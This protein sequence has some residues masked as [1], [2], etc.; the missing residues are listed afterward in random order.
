M[1]LRYILFVVLVFYLWLPGP[2]T[3]NFQLE[4]GGAGDYISYGHLTDAFLAGKVHLLKEPDPKLI[5][6][7]NPYDRWARGD[8]GWHDATYYKE[9]YYLY[10]GA[11]PVIVLYL[12]FKFL[13]GG[14]MTDRLASAIFMYGTFLFSAGILILIQKL[15]FPH[16]PNWKLLLSIAVIGFCNW[17]PFIARD[18][19]GIYNV[20]IAC[21]LFF[22]T[23][24][25]YFLIKA[26][27]EKKSN[28]LFW[29]SLFFGL[30]IGARLSLILL[31]IFLPIVW[32]RLNKDKIAT[33][34]N[35]IFLFAPYAICLFIIGLYNYFRFGSFFESGFKYQ[36]GLFDLTRYS[37]F[38]TGN[39][40]YSSFYYLFNRPN[41]DSNFP[42]VHIRSGPDYVV[43]FATEPIVGLVPSVPFVL[44]PVIY[45]LY[46][47][48]FTKNINLANVV[49]PKLEFLLIA[50][51]LFNNLIIVSLLGPWMRYIAEFATYF[52]LASITIWFYFDSKYFKDINRNHIL[53]KISIALGVFS[54]LFW[55]GLGIDEIRLRNNNRSD[56]VALRSFF[57]PVT[58]ILL[59]Q[60]PSWEAIKQNIKLVP[61]TLQP[62]SSEPGEN[63]EKA[64]DG[65]L[66]TDWIVNGNRSAIIEAIPG[67]PQVIK[68]IWLLPRHT[69]LYESWENINVKCFFE[70]QLL[71]EKNFSFPEAS[72]KR[73]QNVKLEPVKVDRVE[74]GFSKPVIINIEG[75][76]VPFDSVNP[77]YTEILFE[78]ED[79]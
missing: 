59:K 37:I 50:L 75:K 57:N 29:G 20:A 9:K 28:L 68:S 27:H 24:T 53:N 56:F 25:I 18:N 71:Q 36:T 39:L 33:I 5:A 65:L 44:L 11:T 76:T 46:K 22:L 41:F 21:E 26:I 35:T 52:I 74:L 51:S 12:P 54:I 45:L 49:F 77:G 17:A 2:D 19:N 32:L 55:T 40:N 6:L 31:S 14:N 69:T 4:N 63:L 70:G 13:T 79:Q 34:K 15:Y 16:L 10:F 7:E 67:K 38:N 62:Y 42:Y 73:I 43:A 78:G 66:H 60:F 23:G 47:W 72:K 8:F 48:F 1:K 3:F 64:T 61:V 58:K 30:A